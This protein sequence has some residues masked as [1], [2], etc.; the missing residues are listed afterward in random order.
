MNHSWYL[1]VSVLRT[2]DL[3]DKGEVGMWGGKKKK[4]KLGR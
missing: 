2:Q 1:N 3:H 4:K